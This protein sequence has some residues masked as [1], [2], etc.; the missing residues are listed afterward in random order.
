[1]EN[2]IRSMTTLL[3]LI[4]AARANL[5]TWTTL[6]TLCAYLDSTFCITFSTNFA[7]I[8]FNNC[9]YLYVIPLFLEVKLEVKLHSFLIYYKFRRIYW[10]SILSIICHPSFHI[11][12]TSPFSV[13]C[14]FRVWGS[15]PFIHFFSYD[16]VIH[17]LYHPLLFLFILNTSL[18]SSCFTPS[19]QFNSW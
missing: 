7:Y 6:Q 2:Y 16:H 18:I 12:T 17:I 15:V 14:H 11:F 8:S 4:E 5:R 10:K 19:V 1:M 13:A 9:Q 3:Q